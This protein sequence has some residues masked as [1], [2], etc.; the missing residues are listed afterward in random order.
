MATPLLHL[1]LLVRD[2]QRSLRFYATYLG[3]DS[4]DARRYPDGTVIVRSASRPEPSSRVSLVAQTV[5]PGVTTRSRPS[6]SQVSS[7]PRRGVDPPH[8]ANPRV[9]DPHHLAGDH[10]LPAELGAALPAST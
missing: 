2:Q 6:A 9:A 1:G 4:A 8:H 5:P 10:H 3:F 7:V